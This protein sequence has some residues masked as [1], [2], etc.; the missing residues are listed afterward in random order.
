MSDRGLVLKGWRAA[1]AAALAGLAAGLAQPPFGLLIGLLGWSVLF[2]L[3]DTVDTDRPL[4]SAFLRGWAMGA[5]Y[6]LISSYWVGEAFL[7]D[8]QAHGWQAPFA[9][10]F[11][12]GGLG[13]LWGAAAAAYRW[14][15]Y[16][17]TATPGAWRVLTFAGAFAVVEWLRGHILSG[18]PWDLPGET[19]RAG[20][21][22]SQTAA[23]IGA[24]GLS[25]VTLAIAATPGLYRWRVRP[26]RP[27]SRRVQRRQAC[28]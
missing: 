12:A 5:A 10:I 19:W 4:R 21:V 13:L 14:L 2:R 17:W 20:G 8:I 28:C 3:L 27:R 11:L 15:V 7:V 9:V 23:M 6:F 25:I 24:Y 22:I 18:F 16:S 26:A 1:G